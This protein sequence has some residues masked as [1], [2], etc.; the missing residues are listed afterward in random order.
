MKIEFKRKG[1]KQYAVKIWRDKFPNLEMDPA[2]GF[3]Y[4]MP[5]DLCHLIV[6]QTLPITNGIF[7]QI[8]EGYTAGT[9]RNSP[10]ESANTRNDSRERR[11]TKQKSQKIVKENL[12]DLAKSERATYVCWQNWL[13]HSDDEKLKF[14]AAEMKKIAEQILSKMSGAE[15][16]IYTEEKLSQ[17]RDVMSEYSQKWQNLKIGESIMIDW[18]V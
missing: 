9:F 1:E 2:P 12:E 8:S 15:R 13:E 16:S 7:G 18:K 11:K 14:K 3:D 4:L 17:I 6:E 10:D 5:H